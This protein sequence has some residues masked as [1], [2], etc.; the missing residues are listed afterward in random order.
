[1]NRMGIQNGVSVRSSTKSAGIA[2]IAQLGMW[3]GM[4]F[5]HLGKWGSDV[6]REMA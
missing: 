3:E 5:V 4:R 1:M 2:A 6:A